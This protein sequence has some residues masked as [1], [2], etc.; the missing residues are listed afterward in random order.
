[1]IKAPRNLYGGQSD[2]GKGNEHALRGLMWFN[3][4]GH[5]DKGATITI[6]GVQ[7]RA[8]RDVSTQRHANGKRSV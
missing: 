8:T 2:R 1:M 3:K 6:G 5:F 7:C 4:D